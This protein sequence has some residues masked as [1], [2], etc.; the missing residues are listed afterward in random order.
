MSSERA[1]RKNAPT[2]GRRRASYI[3]NGKARL[4][5]DEVTDMTTDRRPTDRP[6]SHRPGAAG[7]ALLATSIIALAACGSAAGVAKPSAVSPGGSTA[8]VGLA[9]PTA[10]V[11]P[12]SATTA[13]S[14]A[15]ASPMPTPILAPS[16]APEATLKTLWDAKG[17]APVRQWNWT[18]AIDPA[19]HIWTAAS[20]DNVFRIFDRD[21]KYLESWGT[22]G[23]GEG[24]LLLNAEG[25]GQGG[26]AFGPDGGFYVAD[27]GHARVLQ[28]DKDRTFVRSWGTFGTG[29]GQFTL[30]LNIYTDPAGHVFVIDD[31]RQDIQEFDGDGTFMRVVTSGMGPYMAVDSTSTVYAIDQDDHTPHKAMLYKYP[32]GGGKI[33]VADLHD[34]VNFATGIVIAPNGDIF[35]ATSD[36]GGANPS[37]LTLIQLDPTGKVL[38]VWPNGAEAIALDPKGDRMYETFSDQVGALRAVA[39]P[40]P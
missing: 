17:P 7:L 31:H 35:I 3:V 9:S 11:A 14:A 22:P 36:T 32:A 6:T 25:N 21:G 13:P 24:Q 1:R 28:F 40:K 20:F 2:D 34:M 18:P 15:P 19:G 29:D 33:A 12:A 37:Y 27:A 5:D 30:P 23:D 26:I 39:L 38:H 4:G 10:T 16:T 8:I